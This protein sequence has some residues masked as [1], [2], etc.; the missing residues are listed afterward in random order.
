[1]PATD[2]YK[3]QHTTVS[4]DDAVCVSGSLS[5][6]PAPRRVVLPTP[7]FP[8]SGGVTLSVHDN[9]YPVAV[10]TFEVP[11]HYGKCFGFIKPGTPIAT[12][13]RGLR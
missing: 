3:E 11:G 9:S 5:G 1:V 10:L 6:S 12:E 8:E 2:G 7:P 4:H 13:E